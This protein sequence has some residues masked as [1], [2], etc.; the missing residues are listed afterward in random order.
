MA[1]RG[2]SDEFIQWYGTLEVIDDRWT[3]E[4]LQGV[5][6]MARSEKPNHPPH[7]AGGW[8][9]GIVG[10]DLL[11]FVLEFGAARAED[12]DLAVGE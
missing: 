5:A 11:V 3:E 9:V 12:A 4:V 7:L 2:A 8:L 1:R 10:E 6:S